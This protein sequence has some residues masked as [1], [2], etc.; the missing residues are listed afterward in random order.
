MASESLHDDAKAIQ[1]A[2]VTPAPPP[3]TIRMSSE[4]SFERSSTNASSNNTNFHLLK[5]R[6]KPIST[7][8]FLHNDSLTICL[9]SSSVFEI[10]SG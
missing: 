9:A 10:N 4:A 8:L 3:E 1:E 7:K 2:A 5:S 6:S